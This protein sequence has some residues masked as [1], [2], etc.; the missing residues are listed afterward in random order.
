MVAAL[1]KEKMRRHIDKTTQ[2][3]LEGVEAGFAYHG[4]K[5]TF[6]EYHCEDINGIK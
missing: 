4:S 3:F 5:E 1:K 2:E 6:E